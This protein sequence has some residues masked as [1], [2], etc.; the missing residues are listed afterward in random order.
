MAIRL[1]C[2][3]ITIV[4][5]QCSALGKRDS[6]FLYIADMLRICPA[7]INSVCDGINSHVY[8]QMSDNNIS[9][10][11]RGEHFPYAFCL[12]GTFKIAIEC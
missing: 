7:F 2:N 10:D 5:S 4:F 6:S 11:E 9:L 8:P 1:N 3:M 12:L